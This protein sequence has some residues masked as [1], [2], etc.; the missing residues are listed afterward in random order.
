MSP[1]RELHFCNRIIVSHF[2]HSRKEKIKNF[3]HLTLLT[4][5]FY[6]CHLTITAPSVK[7]RKGAE[8]TQEPCFNL[9]HIML[10]SSKI[11]RYRSR[12]TI[13]LH[14]SKP[15]LY[16]IS[17]SSHHLVHNP[18]KPVVISLRTSTVQS[19]ASIL[20]PIAGN[21][22]FSSVFSGFLYM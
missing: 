8:T 7:S 9:S 15:S 18:Y 5:A 6:L 2:S 11:D 3:C 4:T 22:L 20:T 12:Y 19:T 14:R 1:F 17:P 13:Y 16:D 21:T 10:K